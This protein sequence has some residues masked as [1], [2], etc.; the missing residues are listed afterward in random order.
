MWGAGRAADRSGRCGV[1]SRPGVLPRRRTRCAARG[2][3][4]VR[5]ILH[6]A[7]LPGRPGVGTSVRPG[8]VVTRRSSR[9]GLTSSA[10][11]H[12]VRAVC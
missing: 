12:D 7:T 5:P 9:L 1:C 4:G 11:L 3:T 6:A 10:D 2:P 8:V